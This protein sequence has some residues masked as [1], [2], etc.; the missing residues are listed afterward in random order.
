[1]KKI[2]G[3]GVTLW[4]RHGLQPVAPVPCNFKLNDRVIF[5]NDYGVLFNQTVIGFSENDNFHGNFIHCITDTWEGSAGWFP[6]HPNQ[7]KAAQ[8]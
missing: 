6:H 5:T 7:L 2:H 3:Q 8:S 1:M 4:E